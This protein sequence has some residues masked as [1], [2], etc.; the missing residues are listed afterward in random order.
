M[1]YNIFEQIGLPYKLDQSANNLRIHAGNE[2][3]WTAL[4]HIAGSWQLTHQAPMLLNGPKGSGK[5]HLMR[6]FEQKLRSLHTELN[7]TW[8][9]SRDIFG[10]H[11]QQ[12]SRLRYVA[13]SYDRPNIDILLLH[14]F[15][16]ME[17]SLGRQDL[18]MQLIG[19]MIQTAKLVIIEARHLP[20]DTALLAPHPDA[21]YLPSYKAFFHQCSRFRITQEQEN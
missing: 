4:H 11:F 19:K 1:D 2:K 8:Q 6:A 5:T 20:S 15:A 21:I 7:I 14:S 16:D 17:D 13:P 9:S 18:F 3:A 12:S 10:S